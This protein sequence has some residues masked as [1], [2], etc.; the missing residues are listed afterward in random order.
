MKK[1]NY[2]NVYVYFSVRCIVLILL[3]MVEN[4]TSSWNIDKKK[5]IK[6]IEG[7]S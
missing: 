4:I 7:W 1:D 5:E 6:E 3:V 2:L